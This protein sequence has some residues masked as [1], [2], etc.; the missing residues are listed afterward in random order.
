MRRQN[1]PLALLALVPTVWLYLLSSIFGLYH[2]APNWTQ[3]LGSLAPFV[4]FKSANKSRPK[5]RVNE[6]T[7]SA[8]ILLFIASLL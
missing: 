8:W 4:R 1:D 2:P 6:I 5:E 7:A 3:S